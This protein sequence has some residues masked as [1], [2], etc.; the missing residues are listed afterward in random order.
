MAWAIFLISA[1]TL[2]GSMGFEA[3]N[4]HAG[5]IYA[6]VA[7]VSYSKSNLPTKRIS[8]FCKLYLEHLQTY[9]AS[10][11]SHLLN[12]GKK[13]WLE[14]SPI[15]HRQIQRCETCVHLS[16]QVCMPLETSRSSLREIT[17]FHQ[18]SSKAQVQY[19][20][21]LICASVVCKESTVNKADVTIG[22]TASFGSQV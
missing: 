20:A 14:P 8:K 7:L 18:P 1:A 15:S 12:L 21:S 3:M 10:S 13:S 2:V 16:H 6:I 5:C 17:R 22:I 19:A 4:L 11:H 9:R